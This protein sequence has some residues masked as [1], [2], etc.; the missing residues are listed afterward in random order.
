MP[1]TTQSMTA[2]LTDSGTPSS[3]TSTA[4]AGA[5]RQFMTVDAA[6][7][8]GTSPTAPTTAS[9]DSQSIIDNNNPESYYGFRFA[10]ATVT[11]VTPSNSLTAYPNFGAA[12]CDF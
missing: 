1:N 10:F 9:P 6:N 11:T 3:I 4:V 2:T 7:F 12:G 8:L 5:A